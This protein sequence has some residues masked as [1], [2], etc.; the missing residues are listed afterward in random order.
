MLI[1]VKGGKNKSDKETMHQPEGVAW[2]HLS[3]PSNTRLLSEEMSETQD[4]KFLIEWLFCLCIQA[5]PRRG[6]PKT[7]H[8]SGTANT[9]QLQ[10][11]R[12]TPYIA[13]SPQ[14]DAV[15]GHT[16]RIKE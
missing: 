5:K 2:R 3:L 4:R 12:S 10:H 11:R 8:Q 9:G 7:Q 15:T 16:E 14:V 6:T 1:H 13:Q